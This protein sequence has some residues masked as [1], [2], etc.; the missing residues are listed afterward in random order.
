VRY[1]ITG[2]FRKIT[3]VLKQ[4]LLMFRILKKKII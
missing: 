2:K 3:T 1:A 4:E